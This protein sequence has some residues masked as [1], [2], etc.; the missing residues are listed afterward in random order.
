MIFVSAEDAPERGLVRTVL[1]RHVFAG[2]TGSARVPGI[3]PDQAS[4]PPQKLIFQKGEERPPSLGQDGA[5][6]TG[7]LPDVPAKVLPG[8]PGA[9]GHV[10]DLQVLDIHDGLGFADRSRGL[11]EKIQTHVRHSFVGSCHLDLLLPE[12]LALRSLAVFPGELALLPD[13]LLFSG[14]HRHDQ[15]GSRVDPETG[16]CHGKRRDTEIHTNLGAAPERPP[17]FAGRRPTVPPF[18]SRWRFGL[19]VLSS[20]PEALTQSSCPRSLG[21]KSQKSTF[22]KIFSTLFCYFLENVLLIPTIAIKVAKKLDVI[23]TGLMDL[24]LFPRLLVVSLFRSRTT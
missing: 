14:L 18:G 10:P 23:S 13:E 15:L 3:D 9:F 16:R 12:M 22:L 11:V 19:R 4:S 1:R 24:D 2:K 6:Q 20:S 7:L 5:V 8:A 21:N 17:R